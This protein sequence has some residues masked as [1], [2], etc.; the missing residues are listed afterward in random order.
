MIEFFY[1]LL[2]GAV[3]FWMW[4]DTDVFQQIHRALFKTRVKE[5]VEVK[6]NG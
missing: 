4:R 1:G 3:L 5:P 6:P 2:A